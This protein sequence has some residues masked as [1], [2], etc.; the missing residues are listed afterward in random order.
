M[1]VFPI[2]CGTA[3]LALAAPAFAD[4]L[5]VSSAQT[6]PVATKAAANNTPGNITVTSSVS[7]TSGTAATINSNNSLT[8][9]G[10]ITSAGSTNT[11]AVLV[12]GTMPLTGITLT[13]TGT[14]SVTGTATGATGNTGLL[15][16]GPGP[17]A[18][19]ITSGPLAG[20][21]SVTGDNAL[22]VSLA[23]PFTGNVTLRSVGVSG[24][25]STAVSV[26]APLTGSLTL[27]GSTVSTGAGGYGLN[28]TAP[29]SGTITNASVLNAGSG[30]TVDSG[31]NIVAG[32]IPLAGVHLGANVTGGFVNDRYY[33][34]TA[35]GVLDPAGTATTTTDSLV[36]GT[37]TSV[38]GGPAIA[39][40][41]GA[42]NPQPIT[43]GAVGAVGSADGYAIVNRGAVQVSLA[44]A[45]QV[46]NGILIGGGGVT[47]TLTG[48]INSQALSSFA[49]SSVDAQSNGIHLLSGAVVPTFINGGIFSV[50]TSVTAAVGNGQPGTGGDAYGVLIDQGAT[51]SS[52]V[53]TGTITAQGVGT[54][55]NAYGIVDHSGTLASINNSGTI[56]ARAGLLQRAI[57]L[58]GSNGTVAVTNTGTITGDIVFG[59]G[60]STL[61]LGTGSAITGV[62]AFGA[63]PSTLNLAGTASL[64]SG[65]SANAASPLNVTLAD[66]SLL[67]L[68]GG[69]TTLGSVSATGNSVL[70]VPVTPGAGPII[71]DG[72]ASFTGQSVVRLSLQS[73]AAQ[74]NLAIIQA[75]TFSTDHLATLVDPS[76]AP[77]LFTATAPTLTDNILSITL[78]RKTAADIGLV[79]GQALLYQN[80]LTALG[81]TPEA[82][83]IANL[84]SQQAVVAAY[85]QITPPSFGRGVLRSA[86]ALSDGGFGAAAGRLNIVNEV[87][88]GG[89]KNQWGVWVQEFGDFNQSRGGVNEAGYRA[90]SFGLAAGIDVPVLG[91]D[92]VGIGAV[93]NYTVLHQVTSQGYAPSE[94]VNVSTQGLLPYVS[95]SWKSLFVQLSGLAAINTYNSSR[96]L[97][98]GTI[99]DTVLSHWTGEQYGA[100]GV[101]GARLHFGNLRVTPSNA[102]AWTSLHQG[103]YDER[104]A[105]AFG[106]GVAK[107][108]NSVTTDTAKVSL[109]YLI[110]LID[111]SLELELHAGYV[112]QFDT[113]ATSTDVH[114]LTLP[115]DPFTLTGDA[116]KTE[117]LSYGGGVGYVQDDFKLKF[118]YDRRQ[119][120]GFHDQ[121]LALSAGFSF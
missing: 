108:T 82:S 105:G 77:Y 3:A 12:D 98:I 89:L 78:T 45:G 103:G 44:G 52:I 95:K 72:T 76:I 49:I 19:T 120:T 83:A 107:S 5:T 104:G 61:N 73:L 74:Q 59:T 109:A 60:S 92:A 64:T 94:P 81:N 85:R 67:S 57:D 35:T 33:V 39:V 62:V 46:A 37:I 6:T 47:T 118:G 23:A 10:T 87:H 14:I 54:N 99:S 22:G 93:T 36:N 119:E 20:S 111:S 31:G 41:P 17:I 84:P 25:N 26:S 68:V 18:G 90:S 48:G 24:A 32:N 75:G 96:Q 42:T 100:N 7:V 63:G 91:L 4:D 38:G 9:S 21:I 121:S 106:L 56:T 101:I 29:V 79:G 27:T 2:L 8:N 102:I 70:V 53:N 65:L 34:V 97:N 51:L 71:V 30:Q 86:Q 66:Q 112:H 88:Q 117:Q 55:R 16:G 13:N 15:I 58:S 43:V 1:R 113:K 116:V 50:A 11:T 80:S 114:F 115:G 28:V 110:K 40:T 69:P